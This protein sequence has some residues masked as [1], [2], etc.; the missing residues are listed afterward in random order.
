MKWNIRVYT[1]EYV[2]KL[3]MKVNMYWEYD[4]SF[5]AEILLLGEMNLYLPFIN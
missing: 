1:R 3:A 4:K 2:E 5:I